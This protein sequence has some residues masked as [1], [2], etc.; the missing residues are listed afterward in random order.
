VDVRRLS[1]GRGV[2]RIVLCAFAAVLGAGAVSPPARAAG[3]L[4]QYIVVL[5]DGVE[6][7]AVAEQHARRFGA[8]VIARYRHVLNGYAAR[9]PSSAAREVSRD[10]RVEFV[11]E[12]ADVS[13]AETTPT[14]VA[15]ITPE[16]AQEPATTLR[17]QGVNVAVIG[18]GVDRLHPELDVAGGVNCTGDKL[19]GAEDP[20]G[21]ETFV[22]G[23]IGARKNSSG[24]VGVVP[25]VR[26]WSVRV[27]K[28]N[29]VG[30]ISALICG[31]DWATGT[32]LD[33]DSANDIAVANM[34]LTAKGSDDENCGLTK[35]DA[36]HLAV[37]RSVGA[38]VT[39]VAAAGNDGADVAKYVPAAYDEVLTVTAMTDLD[40]RAGGLAR[41]AG[42]CVPEKDADRVADDS[43]IFFSNFAS[44]PSDT[45]HTIAAPG[46]CIFSTRP[47]GGYGVAS[48]TSFAAPHVAGAVAACIA[49]SSCAGLPPAGIV[50]TLVANATA[51]SGAS[52]EYGFLGDP[53]RAANGRYYGYLVRATSVPI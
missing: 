1:P 12:D 27:L 10:P 34:S 44:L 20:A 3:T 6:G 32:R 43:A 18:T 24:I 37:C 40:G 15:R 26:L 53:L 38:G 50:A 31:I 46:V 11:A 21:H 8:A 35:K 25:G 7:E 52:P 16:A 28:K 19:G 48:G 45:A 30:T 23:I 22:A 51:Y 29:A 41:V 9:L 39:Y 42:T 36:L 33:D 17:A 4:E 2:L 5:K 14:G 13:A 47:G 49:W